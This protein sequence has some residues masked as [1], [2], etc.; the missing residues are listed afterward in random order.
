MI[1]LKRVHM[2]WP[3]ARETKYSVTLHYVTT[4]WIIKAMDHGY[5]STEVNATS[6]CLRNVP[7]LE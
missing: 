2:K 5:L 1:I 6:Y 3:K 7:C 4:Q